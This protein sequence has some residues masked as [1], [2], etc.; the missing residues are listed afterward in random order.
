MV[1]QLGSI[2]GKSCL[3]ESAS[4][5]RGCRPVPG[6][7]GEYHSAMPRLSQLLCIEERLLY[8]CRVRHRL[9]IQELSQWG[10]LSV[11]IEL[12]A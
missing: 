1:V 9:V 6:T 3:S 8:T 2:E 12:Y 11:D 4:P 5:G 7:T 10:Q